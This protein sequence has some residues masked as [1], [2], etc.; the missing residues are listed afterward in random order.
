MRRDALAPI[1]DGS[2]GAF[3]YFIEGKRAKN[4]ESKSCV[5]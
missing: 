1:L 5:S 2:Q 4:T 3:I